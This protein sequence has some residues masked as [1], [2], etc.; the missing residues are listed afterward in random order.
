MLLIRSFT[1]DKQHSLWLKITFYAHVD[2]GFTGSGIAHDGKY[3]L[4]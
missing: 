4:K 2:R 1:E 3:F